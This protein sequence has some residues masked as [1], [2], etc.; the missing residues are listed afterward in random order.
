MSNLSNITDIKHAYYINLEKR[1]DRKI[2][3]EEQLTQLE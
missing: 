2:F 3:V 1:T